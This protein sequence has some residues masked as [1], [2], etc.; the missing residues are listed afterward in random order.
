MGLRSH[1]R[2]ENS[3]V[4][5]LENARDNLY[6]GPIKGAKVDTHWCSTV[7]SPAFLCNISLLFYSTCIYLNRRCFSG[8]PRQTSLASPLSFLLGVF[9][10]PFFTAV[11]CVFVYQ[12]HFEAWAAWKEIAWFPNRI[13]IF[14]FLEGGESEIHESIEKESISYSIYKKSLL[15]LCAALLTAL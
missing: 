10:C 15:S 5:L 3:G 4:L 13:F 12:M 1:K 11:F 7:G 14:V 9:P 6:A 8:K 2:L